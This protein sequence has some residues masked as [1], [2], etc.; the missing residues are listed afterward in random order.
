[1]IQLPYSQLSNISANTRSLLVE[2]VF[3]FPLEN[4]SIMEQ[5]NKGRIKETEAEGRRRTM[6]ERQCAVFLFT[7]EEKE[8]LAILQ[9][10]FSLK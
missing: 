4:G 2:R 10:E 6:G 7:M 1:M 8:H 9:F 5:M 3:L